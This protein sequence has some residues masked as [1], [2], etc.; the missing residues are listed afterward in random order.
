M[1]LGLTHT[2]PLL[3]LRERTSEPLLQVEEALPWPKEALNPRAYACFLRQLQGFYA[4]VETLLAA[5]PQKATL[6]LDLE[7]RWKTPLLRQDLQTLN[8]QELPPCEQLPDLTGVAG[9]LGCLY[10]LESLT[11][12]G[13]ILM[14]EVV[15]KLR[16][17]LGEAFAFVGCYGEDTGAR[18]N[19]VRHAVRLHAT[20]L[21][22]TEPMCAA[23]LATLT[24]LQRWLA[25]TAQRAWQVDRA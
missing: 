2:D 8:L 18:W 25:E 12:G 5:H 7:R 17:T 13:R 6:G 21:T 24:A 15:P 22:T 1:S 19:E 3:A 23:A 10:I 9:A 20:N 4:P 14:R 16:P 11:L